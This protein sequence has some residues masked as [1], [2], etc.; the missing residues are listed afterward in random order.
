MK[1][2]VKASTLSL[3]VLVLIEMLNSLNAISEDN[4]LLTMSPLVN[5]WLL[6][7]ITWSMSLHAMIVYVPFF[8]NIFSIYALN[9]YECALVFAFSFPV[10]LIDEVLKIFARSS[11]EK[12]LAK[13]LK[14][15]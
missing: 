5:P 13:R 15:D 7:A 1:G 4:S 14:Q 2:K 11:N 3:S 8:N 10:I 12:A 9:Q 6:V